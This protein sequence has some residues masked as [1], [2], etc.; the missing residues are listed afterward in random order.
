ML[1]INSHDITGLASLNEFVVAAERAF[2]IMNKGEFHM[3]DRMHVDHEGNTLLLM[4]CF[5]GKYFGTKIVSLFP[6]NKKYGKPALYG[7][8]ML[9][10]GD[11]G[12]PLAM[13][14]GAKLTAMRTGAVGGLGIK[15]LAYPESRSACIIGA[16]V[17][18]LHQAIFTCHQSP[19][20]KLMVFDPGTEKADYLKKEIN[21]LYP[22]VEIVI[23]DDPEQAVISSDIVITATSSDDPVLADNSESLRGKTYIAIG[24]YKP[25]M[26]ELPESLFRIA[27]RIF[28]DTPFA[29]EESGDISVPL[30]NRW[31][32]DSQVQEMHKLVA[33]QLQV[34]SGGSET[35]IF[36]ACGMALFDLVVAGMLYEKA[37]QKDFGQDIKF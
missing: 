30:E 14:D 10:D 11:T 7:N 37:I 35:R 6:E 27:E 33:G 3:P 25:S 20:E 13:I 19:V 16:G 9:N 24:S 32:E 12:E 15:Y 23:T 18:G 2:E 26:R 22:D 36:K 1:I 5:S 4:P 31:I 17:Q 34:D 29:R 28:I 8:M 21:K